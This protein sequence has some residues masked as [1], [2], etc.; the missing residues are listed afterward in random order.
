MPRNAALSAARTQ[1]LRGVRPSA[2]LPCAAGKLAIA[3]ALSIQVRPKLLDTGG[4]GVADRAFHFFGLLGTN[5][6]EEGG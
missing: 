5:E 4:C 6:M 2:T 1:T 3:P